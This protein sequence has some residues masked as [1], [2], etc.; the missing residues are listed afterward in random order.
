MAPLYRWTGTLRNRSE[1]S[2][3]VGCTAL[4]GYDPINANGVLV[5]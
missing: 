1:D 5:G 3:K 2:A 4:V